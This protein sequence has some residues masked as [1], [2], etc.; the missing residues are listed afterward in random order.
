MKLFCYSEDAVVKTFADLGQ[1]A[2]YFNTSLEQMKDIVCLS[3]C[4]QL[5]QGRF[6]F[7]YGH[8]RYRMVQHNGMYMMM[9]VIA[10]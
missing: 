9:P 7:D 6:R 2:T 4:G 10:K 5:Y 3:E 8:E 1:A